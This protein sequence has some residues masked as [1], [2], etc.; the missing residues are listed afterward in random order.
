MIRM[1]KGTKKSSTEVI[2]KAVAFFGPGGWG[3]EVEERADC[4]THLVGGG[5]HVFV[6]VTDDA[7]PGGREIL[8][9]GR[10]WETQIRQFMTEV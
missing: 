10:E 8:V 5:G 1:G 3:L 9:E 7:G 2:A 4:C 6:Q